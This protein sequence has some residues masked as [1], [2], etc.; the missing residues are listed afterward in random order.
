M[1]YLVKKSKKT[2]QLIAELEMQ[3]VADNLVVPCH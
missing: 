3:N 2:Q 1:V